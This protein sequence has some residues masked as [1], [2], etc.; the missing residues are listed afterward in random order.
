M[1]QLLVSLAGGL[2]VSPPIT[3]PTFHYSL[4][5]ISVSTS[6]SVLLESGRNVGKGINDHLHILK[7]P[8]PPGPHGL[9]QAVGV[10][11]CVRVEWECP[12]INTAGKLR[13][14]KKSRVQG[15]GW[16]NK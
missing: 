8:P 12:L 7:S 13:Q 6:K 2:D 15:D 1:A 5:P 10:V 11:S 14:E 3:S 9:D 16:R 4:P